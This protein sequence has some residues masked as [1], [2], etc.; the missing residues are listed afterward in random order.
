MEAI[1]SRRKQFWKGDRWK[2][3]SIEFFIT[4]TWK[5]F[6]TSLTIVLYTFENK[7]LGDHVT[8]ANEDD[9]GEEFQDHQVSSTVLDEDMEET[10]RVAK[11]S[12][13]RKKY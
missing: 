5:R 10:N 6:T 11:W 2:S 3:C 8:S 12:Q 9:I 1:E 13:R 7:P 4:Y